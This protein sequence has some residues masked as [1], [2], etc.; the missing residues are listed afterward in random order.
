M[1]E[2]GT[3][4]DGSGDLSLQI[5]WIRCVSFAGIPPMTLEVTLVF[6]PVTY[7]SGGVAEGELDR[8][9]IAQP[10]MTTDP[11]LRGPLVHEEPRR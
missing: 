4:T 10:A 6:G 3:T 9:E 11:Q 2:G 8:G 1:A 7:D 5:S